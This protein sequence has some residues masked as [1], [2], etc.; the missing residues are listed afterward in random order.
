MND[1]NFKY[2]FSEDYNPQY[3]NGAFGGIGPKGEIIIHFYC[4]RGAVPYQVKHHL[5]ESGH[6]LDPVYIEPEDFEG[7]FVRYIQSGVIL[8]RARAIEIYNWLGNMLG[9]DD[10]HAKE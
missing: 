6:L 9:N 10:E 4:E 7:S 8:D 3:V 5:D 2:I 1:I